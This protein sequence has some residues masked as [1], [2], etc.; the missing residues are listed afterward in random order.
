LAGR[1]RSEHRVA[2]PVT[3]ESAD[4]PR[5]DLRA[6]GHARGIRALDAREDDIVGHMNEDHVDTMKRFCAE[7]LGTASTDVQMLCVDADGFD[8]RA[9]DA[10]LRFE[11]PEAVTDADGARQQFIR[12]ARECRAA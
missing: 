8:L 6:H 3:T 10:V 7:R 5:G 2:G 1:D 4:G 12:M 11:F 9:D